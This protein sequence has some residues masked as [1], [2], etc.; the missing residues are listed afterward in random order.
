MK[1]QAILSS[2]SPAVQW[3]LSIKTG[4]EWRTAV[5]TRA[6]FHSFDIRQRTPRKAASMPSGNPWRP[7]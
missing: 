6:A 1:Q 7:P 3:C 5:P 2:Y 4:L